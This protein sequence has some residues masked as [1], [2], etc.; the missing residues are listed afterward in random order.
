M[1]QHF[2][3][4]K[5][6]IKKQVVLEKLIMWKNKIKLDHYLMSYTKVE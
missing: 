1:E 2:I 4:L 3:L 6:W 5:K